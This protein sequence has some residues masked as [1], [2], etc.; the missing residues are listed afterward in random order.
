MEKAK[1][2]RLN[3]LAHKAKAEGLSEVE[4]AER[5]V[6]RTEYIDAFKANMKATLE[7]I[8]VEEEDGTLVALKK[9]AGEPPHVHEKQCGCGC[10]HDHEK[11]DE[12]PQQ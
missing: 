6:L 8:V 7:N 4:K 5:D 2:K 9:R 3:E 10:H 1:I 12:I 11:E